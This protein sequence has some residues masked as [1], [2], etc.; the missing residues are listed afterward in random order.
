MT[1]RDANVVAAMAAATAVG[2][3][4]ALLGACWRAL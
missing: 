4:L 2:A 3:L 1:D